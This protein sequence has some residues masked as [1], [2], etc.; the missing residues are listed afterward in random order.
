LRPFFATNELRTRSLSPSHESEG[1]VPSPGA[2]IED[3]QF[4]AAKHPF[5]RGSVLCVSTP[6]IWKP[7][8]GSRHLP[9]KAGCPHPALA[10]NWRLRRVGARGLHFRHPVILSAPGPVS[11]SVRALC[12]LRGS[13]LHRCSTTK[14]TNDT[15]PIHA[16]LARPP[17]PR[18]GG[19]TDDSPA[20]ERWVPSTHAH[21]APAG[22]TEPL[23]ARPP[24]CSRVTSARKLPGTR[25]G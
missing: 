16:T 25:T 14:D 15:N 9:L 11:R 13:T 6:P 8:N 21:P 4:I 24:T 20:R 5:R 10:S 2:C 22:A 12:A 17:G 18:P 19:P 7:G 23:P 1:R 3:C